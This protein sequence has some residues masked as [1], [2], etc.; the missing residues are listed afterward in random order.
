MR[1]DQA[2]RTLRTSRAAIFRFE[3]EDPAFAGTMTMTWSM[4]AV[5][6]GTEVGIVAENVP[7]GISAPAHEAGMKSSLANLARYV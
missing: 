7:G 5:D 4:T 2:S 6:D 1:T 3:S